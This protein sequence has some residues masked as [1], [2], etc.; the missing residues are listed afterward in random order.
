MDLTHHHAEP[1]LHQ[2]IKKG[3][4]T[5]HFPSIS[6]AASYAQERLNMLSPDYRRFEY[7]HEFKV[8]ISKKLLSLQR[9]LLDRYRNK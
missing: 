6:E 5:K 2:W 1:L 8:G 9:Q 3:S 7:P 4:A